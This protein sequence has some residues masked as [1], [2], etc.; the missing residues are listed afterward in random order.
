MATALLVPQIRRATVFCSL[1]RNILLNI[2]KNTDI[3]IRTSFFGGGGGEGETE[4]NMKI[5]DPTIRT[6]FQTNHFPDKNIK[7]STVALSVQLSILRL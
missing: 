7:K 5:Q 1:L 6:Y 3:K 2:W 4:G